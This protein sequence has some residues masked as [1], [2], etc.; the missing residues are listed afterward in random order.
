MS[1]HQEKNII[2]IVYIKHMEQV[3]NNSWMVRGIATD[4]PVQEINGA[5]SRG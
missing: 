3:A 2:D 4:Q 5:H 1:V